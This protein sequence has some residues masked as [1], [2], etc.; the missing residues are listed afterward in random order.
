MEATAR[1]A[2][3]SGQTIQAF[4]MWRRM[5]PEGMLKYADRVFRQTGT[6]MTAEFADRLTD[7]MKR[8]EGITDPKQLQRA[9][10]NKAGQMPEWAY[11]SMSK[12]TT[13]QLQ[14]IA[15][16]QVLMD[17]SNE[18]PKSA[19][20]KVSSIQAMSHLI[21]IKTAARNIL[22]NLSFSA[23]EKLANT[24]AV[25]IDIIASKFT[26]RRSLTYDTAI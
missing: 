1:K 9:I 15:M 18:V 12:K 13:E 3:T 25:P 26:G 6:K 8:I 23:A 19:W 11:Q 2:K 20:R 5:T 22:G 7:S 21:N 24:V 10:M 17:I 4:A 14:D 16:A